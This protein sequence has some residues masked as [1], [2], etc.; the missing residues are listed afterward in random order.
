MLL[1]FTIICTI[2][3]I[4]TINFFSIIYFGI[5][6]WGSCEGEE[7]GPGFYGVGYQ[8]LTAA[9]TGIFLLH[10]AGFEPVRLPFGG[11]CSN[12]NHVYFSAEC[13]VYNFEQE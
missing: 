8:F 5:G 2:S 10:H 6:D 9:S 1:F 7:L 3:T 11:R 13:L 4:F 12:L